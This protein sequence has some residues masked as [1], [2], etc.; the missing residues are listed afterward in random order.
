M[1]ILTDEH[2]TSNT[3]HSTSN[4]DFVPFE[5]PS[6][7]IIMSID[8]LWQRKKHPHLKLDPILEL[9]LDV[10]CVE[11]TNLMSFLKSIEYLIGCWMLNVERWMFIF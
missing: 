10:D 2:S 4:M 9:N 6:F 5:T 8:H 3:Q 11:T 1:N 7:P